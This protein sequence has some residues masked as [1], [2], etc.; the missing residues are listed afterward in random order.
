MRARRHA[1]SA[2]LICVAA[3]TA[4]AAPSQPP[5]LEAASRQLDADAG[6]LIRATELRLSAV[7]SAD[8]D[9]CVPGQLRHFVQAESDF[10]QAADGLLTRLR[11]LGYDQVVDDLDLRDDDQGVAV[12][13]NPRTRLEFEL[14]VLSGEKPGVRVVGKTTCYTAE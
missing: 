5:T 7:R 9:T 10:A 13:R 3:V 14:T 11:A 1:L 12:L 6:E 8:D 4:C 2:M